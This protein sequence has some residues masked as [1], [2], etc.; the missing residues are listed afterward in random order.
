MR[1]LKNYKMSCF[2]FIIA[3]MFCCFTT[4]KTFAV[5]TT[6]T[7]TY[8]DLNRLETVDQ[9]DGIIYD[10]DYD[11]VGNIVLKTTTDYGSLDN[12]G[13]GLSNADEILYGTDPD[14]PDSDFDDMPDGWEVTYGTDP[15]LDDANNDDDYDGISNI[16]E[17]IAGTPPNEIQTDLLLTNLTIPSPDI[18]D[19]RATNSITAGPAYEVETGADVSFT[20]G[21]NIALK[22]GFW[23][24]NGSIFQLY[25]E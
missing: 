19:Y 5:Q 14:N 20:A 12:D 21:N 25:M 4:I 16:D 2:I 24:H 8:D 15:L 17:F 9:S 11:E 22:P 6:I 7:N 1:I 23:L 18:K 13:D 3:S 10:Y